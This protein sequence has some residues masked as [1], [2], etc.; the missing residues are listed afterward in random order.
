M[1]MPPQKEITISVVRP[2]TILIVIFG[3]VILIAGA[4]IVHGYTKQREL[5]SW[6]GTISSSAASA[7]VAGSVDNEINIDQTHSA[8]TSQSEMLAELNRYWL[9]Q[10]NGLRREKQLSVLVTDPRLVATAGEWA[11]EMERRGEITH[12][13]MD[14]KSMH[15]W[16]DTKQLDF[17]ERHSEGGWKTNYFVENIARFYTELSV[18]QMKLALD[19]ILADFL[20]E[21]PG[22]AHYESIYYLDWNSVGLGYA[23]HESE[24]EPPRMYFVFHYGSLNP[25]K[26]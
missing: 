14:G 5:V 25:A 20:S 17:T 15:Q 4:L 21:G 10:V 8:S 6:K 7:T 1:Q 19:R 11:G 22:G 3:L 9:E 26:P 24:T 16:I 23:S 12:E 18:D 2:A 13:R